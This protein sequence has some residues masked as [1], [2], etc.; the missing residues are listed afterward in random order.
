MGEA[1]GA[2]PYYDSLMHAIVVRADGLAVHWLGA[3]GN[4]WVSTPH[5]DRLAAG[6]V[7]FDWH[8][9]DGSAAVPSGLPIHRTDFVGAVDLVGADGLIWVETEQ[10]RPPWDWPDEVLAEYFGDDP[11]AEDPP[12]PLTEPPPGP[13]DDRTFDALQR[14]FAAAV[15]AFD[16]D[17]GALVAALDPEGSALVVVT[18]G[19]G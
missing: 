6:G 15:T 10:L 3:Y 18:S 13:L 1:T 16:A 14:S 17:V 5:L 9:A 19:R 8:F 4:E 11:G 7:V 12:E 2:I